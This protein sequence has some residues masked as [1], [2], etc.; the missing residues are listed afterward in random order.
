MR[1]IQLLIAAAL[2]AG[3]W[4][5]ARRRSSVSSPP[6]VLQSRLFLSILAFVAVSLAWGFGIYRLDND[7]PFRSPPGLL[8]LVQILRAAALCLATDTLLRLLAPHLGTKRLRWVGV[9]LGASFVGVVGGGP[10]ML[11]VLLLVLLLRKSSWPAE[12]HGWRRLVGLFAAPLF[13]L[14][15]LMV[16]QVTVLNGNADIGLSPGGDPWPPGLVAGQL[17]PGL[18]LE[19]DL[20]RP[21]DFVVSLARGLLLAQ[22]LLLTIQFLTLPVRLRGVSLRRR[23][24]INY[25]FIRIIP[26]GLGII[27]FVLSV[28]AGFGLHKAAMIRSE[29]ES[30]V[31]QGFRAAN[32]L[33]DGKGEFEL[34]AE[35][36]R[37]IGPDGERSHFLIRTPLGVDASPGTPDS[38]RLDSLS[39]SLIRVTDGG[40]VAIGG[41]LWLRARTFDVADTTR[42]ID[43]YVPV[44][45]LHLAR[46]AVQR[47][48]DIRIT[49]D[50]Q[51]FI[52]PTSVT[53]GS[54][55]A[56]TS[57]P[58]AV[59]ARFREPPVTPGLLEKRLVLSRS[60][61][62]SGN[63][64]ARD[65]QRVSGAI[66]LNLS[67]APT[68]MVPDRRELILLVAGNVLTLGFLLLVILIVGATEGMAVRTGRGILNALF[69]DVSALRDAAQ[70][71]GK[72]DLDYRVPV[73]GQDEIATVAR[74]FNEMAA[75]LK[76]QQ[77][78]LV[79]KKRLE[80]DLA[81]ARDIQQRLLPQAP[82]IIG[83]VDL[84]GVSIPAV[85]V[86]GDLFAF[87]NE[88]PNRLGL[89]LG[90]VSGKSVPA[91]ILMST[92][93]AAL[94]AESNLAG[95]AGESLVRLNRILLEQIEMGRFVTLVYALLDPSTG[96]LEFASAGHNPALLMS[97]DG[98]VE[99]LSASGPPLGVL[100]EATYEPIRRTLVTGDVLVLYSDGITEAARPLAGQATGS[101]GG[102][103]DMEFFD[104]ARLEAVVT[105]L[106]G[107]S[108]AAIM[109]GVLKSVREFS[110]DEAQGDDITLLIVKFTGTG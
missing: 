11:G 64:R 59:A 69:D 47:H 89:A 78:E 109:A 40:L 32:R 103:E 14:V 87:F 31:E 98:T 1:L 27:F 82:P 94:R 34:L 13:L 73:H 43:V 16:P 81:L 35:A 56:W 101:P 17:T 44:D 102:P 53:T 50:P 52:G 74:A 106:K 3:A 9:L 48:V 21:L 80:A 8:A 95:A 24:A 4:W 2:L 10:G 18:R 26:A 39:D 84:A 104:E 23:L 57:R 83:G 71:F 77:G 107:S 30:T 88:G 99:W 7:E 20:I 22:L 79:E 90:D 55:T 33:V 45:S 66:T 5:Y 67:I 61:V 97:S 100:A 29:L 110:G 36:R 70:R 92:T 72:G 108:S 68:Y 65:Q 58:I 96:E 60:F 41:S 42:R 51:L 12:V 76:A 15:L 49:A 91:A 19:L 85:E 54:D 37:L 38:L 28:W 86:G 105:G 75:S 46:L 6:D 93:L 25:F 63:W 62:G